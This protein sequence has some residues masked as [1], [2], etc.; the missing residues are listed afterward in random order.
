MYRVQLEVNLCQ[1]F[2]SSFSVVEFK[3]VKNYQIEGMFVEKN[4][5]YCLIQWMISKVLD[6]D[7]GVFVFFFIQGCFIYFFYNLFDWYVLWRS[8]F[9]CFDICSRMYWNYVC[10]FI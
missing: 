9:M 10:I 8:F 1:G 4:M 2:L 7:F 3:Q 5:V 6:V